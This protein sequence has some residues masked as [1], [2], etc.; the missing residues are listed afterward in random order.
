[1]PLLLLFLALIV[2]SGL[3]FWRLNTQTG[4]RIKN[5]DIRPHYTSR[6]KRERPGPD[7]SDMLD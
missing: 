4:Y 5:R 1:M 3:L 7:L 6:P 2:L